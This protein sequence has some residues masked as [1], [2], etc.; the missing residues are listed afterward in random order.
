MCIRDRGYVTNGVHLPTWCAAEWKK[1]FKD[2]FDENFF[3]DQS[4]QKI[5]EAVYGIPDEEI[6][7]TR[8]KQKAKLLDYIKSKCSKDWLRSQ[9]VS[10]THLG[11]FQPEPAY[12]GSLCLLI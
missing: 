10:Y 2:N 6:W 9:A 8:L 1:L 7:N 4:N 5:W 11:Y 3:C 12:G